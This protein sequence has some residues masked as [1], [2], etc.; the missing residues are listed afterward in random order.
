LYY[1]LHI[2]H[3]NLTN[4]Q[5]RDIER[6]QKRGLRIMLAEILYEAALVEC[7]PKTLEGRGEDMCVNLIKTLL[8]PGHKLYHLLPPK[9]YMK[10][11]LKFYVSD[12]IF[13]LN[14]T[15]SFMVFLCIFITAQ[16]SL[17]ND[18]F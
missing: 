7:N 18:G 11:E 8:D 9:F 3:G 4:E 1:W 2:W 14:G 17:L 6:I 12:K 5:T 16:C 13:V 10:Y 15:R